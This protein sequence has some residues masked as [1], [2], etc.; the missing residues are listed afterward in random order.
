MGV[1]AGAH[2]AM[3]AKIATSPNST[4]SFLVQT[5]LILSPPLEMD[6]MKSHRAASE[7]YVQRTGK[8][9]TGS[10]GITSLW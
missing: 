10:K 5:V 3:I 1:G 4:K 7:Q 8:K 6:S 9:R 2:A